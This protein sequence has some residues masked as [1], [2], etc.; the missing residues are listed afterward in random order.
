M[1][2][3]QV[4]FKALITDVL[5]PHINGRQLASSIRHKHLQLPIIFISAY[6]DDAQSQRFIYLGRS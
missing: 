4:E 1:K 2:A 3:D 6:T 5:M